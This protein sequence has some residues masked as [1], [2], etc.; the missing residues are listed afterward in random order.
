MGKSSN[1]KYFSLLTAFSLTEKIIAFIYQAVIAAVLGAGIVTDCFYSASQ[2]FDLIDNTV[3]GALVVVIINRYANVCAEKN[4]TAGV[5][6]LSRL[7]TILSIIMAVA[8]IIVFIFANPFSYFIAPGFDNYARKELIK[9]IRLLC[10]LPPIL[11][12][13][14]LA[15]GML[16]IKNCFIIANSRSLC[17]SI[18]GILAVLFFSVRNPENV[19]I[20]CCGYIAANVLFSLLLFIR[21]RQFGIIRF[22]YPSFDKDIRKL[23][24]MAVPAI[25]SKGIVRISMMIDQIISSMLGK[26]SVTYLVYSHSLYYFV[27]SLLIVNLCV[28]MLTDFTNSC[29]SKNYEQMIKKLHVSISSILLILAPVTLLTLC[30]SREI[31]AIA[32][33]RGAFGSESTKIV[34]MLLFFYAI[35]FIPTMLNSLHTQVLHAFGA[36]QIAMRNSLIS[37]G[38][39][40]ALSI[41]LSSTL[42]IAGIALGTTASA[43]FVIILYKNSVR[44]YLPGYDTIFDLIFVKKLII[45]LTGCGGVIAIIKLLIKSPLLSFAVATVAGFSVFV[46]VL[47]V[48]KEDILIGYVKRI[49]KKKN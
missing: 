19:K 26:G 47:Y 32:Y 6:F 48:M 7:Y 35:G 30:F 3:L 14:T 8:A 40:I 34:G 10:V 28:I 1:L 45:G 9:C 13:A 38:I 23:F 22:G 5:E 43:G 49:T 16:R 4:E 44:K 33:Q 29:V 15:Q 12:F 18:C 11:V 41:V 36:M 25:I 24:V 37:F 2:L 20:L 21:S 42:G 46:L 27:Q 31:T 39:N 17:I